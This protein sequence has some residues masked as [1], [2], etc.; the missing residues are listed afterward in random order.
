MEKIKAIWGRRIT[1]M[2]T[3]KWTET[4]F[5]L[6][7]AKYFLFDDNR[8]TWV[9]DDRDMKLMYHHNTSVQDSALAYVE[10]LIYS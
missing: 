9:A 5:W 8:H 3:Y 6:C 2:L 7:I 10:I 4:A 1:I